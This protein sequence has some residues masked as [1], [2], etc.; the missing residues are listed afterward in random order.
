MAEVE[1][2]GTPLVEQLVFPKLPDSW[3][4]GRIQTSADMTGLVD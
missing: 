1:E 3:K 2:T 4:V